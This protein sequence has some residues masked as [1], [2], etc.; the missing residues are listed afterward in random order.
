MS[1]TML[2]GVLRMPFGLAMATPTGQIQYHQ[3]GVQAADEIEKLTRQRDEARAEVE[4]LYDQVHR[5]V[6]DRAK[7]QARA[8]RLREQNYELQRERDEARAE[9]ERLRAEKDKLRDEK[10]ALHVAV[11]RIERASA[12]AIYSQESIYAMASSA[13]EALEAKP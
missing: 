3:R 11:A 12:G 6:D 8:D 4:N 13:L 1:G 5:W 7:A 10:E 2:L 9:V